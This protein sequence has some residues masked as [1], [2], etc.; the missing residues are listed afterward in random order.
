MRKPNQAGQMLPFD[1]C[2]EQHHFNN[3]LRIID[4]S[5]VLKSICQPKFLHVDLLHSDVF[6]SV[7]QPN[8]EANS[9]HNFKKLLFTKLFQKQQAK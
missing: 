9:V 8:S 7:V 5:S 6:R 1:F 3:F 2:Y 4:R